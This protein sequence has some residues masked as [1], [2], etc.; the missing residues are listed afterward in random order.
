M[1]IHFKSGDLLIATIS[2]VDPNF[3]HTVVLLCRHD[4]DEGTYGLVL[5]RPIQVPAQLREQ[6]PF[7]INEVFFG[8]PVQTNTLQVLHTYGNEIE[9]S[10]EVLPGIWL[11]GDFEELQQGL[12]SHCFD[13]ENCRFYLGYSGWQ[14]DQLQ[15]EYEVDSWIKVRGNREFVMNTATERLWSEAVK[16]YGNGKPLYEHFPENPSFN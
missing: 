5:N 16:L 14:C 12:E 13:S 1:S 10:T 2:L 9:G 7:A 4:D 3:Q 6:M 15:D 8:G 11:G